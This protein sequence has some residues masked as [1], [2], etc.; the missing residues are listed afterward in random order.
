MKGLENESDIQRGNVICP[1]EDLCPVFNCFEAEMQILEIPAEK[2]GIMAN[3]YSC[4]M[5][6]HTIIDEI[7]IDILGEIDRK[8]KTE[9]K[10][11][12]LRSQCRA[13]VLIKSNNV[14]C[15]EKFEKF[16]ALG[17]FTLRDSG[18]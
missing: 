14:L 12:F 16:P 17:R 13:R 2:K 6:M 1:P 18:K 7:S 10:V 3:G 8:T 11:K 9:K 4:I 5:H 15:G